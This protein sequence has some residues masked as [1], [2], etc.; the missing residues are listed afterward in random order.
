MVVGVGGSG[1]HSLTRLASHIADYELFEVNVGISKFKTEIN[2]L[3][4]MQYFQI[5]LTTMMLHIWDFVIDMIDSK[6]MIRVGYFK[7]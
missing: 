3:V 2:R 4:A 7:S 1:R 6:A 5:L